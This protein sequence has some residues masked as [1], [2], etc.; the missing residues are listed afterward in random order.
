MVSPSED[1]FDTLL[2]R[3]NSRIKDG[4]GETIYEVGIGG[5]ESLFE[6]NIQWGKR[7]RLMYQ[8][9]LLIWSKD[10]YDEI[11]LEISWKAGTPQHKENK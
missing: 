2:S 11:R 5:K 9:C 4:M 7:D 6:W 10:S 1:D 3:L 8:L